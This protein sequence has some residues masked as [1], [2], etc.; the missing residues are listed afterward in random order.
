MTG[1]AGIIINHQL[2]RVAQAVCAKRL[3]HVQQSGR[4]RNTTC[5]TAWRCP[6]FA[7]TGR[8]DRAHTH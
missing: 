8:D 7:A 1:T 5:A 3:V 2:T 6:A 4:A